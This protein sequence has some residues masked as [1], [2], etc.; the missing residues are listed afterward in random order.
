MKGKKPK[1]YI[2]CLVHTLKC[3]MW[4][5]RNFDVKNQ[6]L[7]ILYIYEPGIETKY[8]KCCHLKKLGCLLQAYN[9]L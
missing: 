9:F 3:T 5:R 8:N 6:L 1:P 7:K 2:F 4:E